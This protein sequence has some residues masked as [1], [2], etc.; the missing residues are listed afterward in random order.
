M[1]ILLRNVARVPLPDDEAV[2]KK[3]FNLYLHSN[4]KEEVIKNYVYKAG[5]GVAYL[6]LNRTK[7]DYVAS[8]LNTEIVDERAEGDPLNEPFV[9]KPD[10]KFREHQTEAVPELLKIIQRDQYGVLKAACSSGKT[11]AMTWVAGHLGKKVL[12]LCDQGNLAGQWKAAFEDIVWGKKATILDKKKDLSADVIIATFQFLH[13]NPELLATMKDMFGCCLIDELHISGAPTYKNVLFKLN[14]KYR[15]GTSATVMRK[16]YSADVVTDLISD[17]SLEMIDV[18]ALVPE[19]RFM[20]SDVPFFSNDPDTFTKTLTKLSEND[21]RN[22]MIVELI[23]ELVISQ[24][25]KILYVGPRILSLEYLHS[26]VKEFCQSVLY[27]GSTTLKQDQALSTG[28]AAGTIDIILTEKKAEKGLDLPEIDTVIIAKPMN[29]ESTVI[30]IVGRG[31][32][33]LEGKLTPVVYDLV[34]TGSL[35]YRFA[36]N[37]YFWYK[38]RGYKM[39]TERPIFL[40]A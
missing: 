29:S 38:K 4:F 15:I 12:V 28:L 3:I 20:A 13:S 32:R 39:P 33:P 2:I 9:L 23:R 6:P 37:R 22:S 17:V 35:A 26:K 1:T 34:D 11:V 25:R 14:N 8:L 18:N 40:G 19:I 24:H 36:K 5:S 7:L 21:K 31:L 27:I 16:G 30:Q 10:F